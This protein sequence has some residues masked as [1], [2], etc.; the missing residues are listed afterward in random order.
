MKK[1]IGSFIV[2]LLSLCLVPVYAQP[3]GRGG[4]MTGMSVPEWSASMTKLFGDNPVFSAAMEHQSKGGGKDMGLKGKMS[5]DNGKSR[6]ELDMSSVTAQFPPGTLEQMKSMGLN[7]DGA[8]QITRPDKKMNYGVY[9]EM[10]AYTEDAMK[11][12]DAG[13]GGSD[14]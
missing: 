14:F 9:P 4:G 5:F 7:F 6:T 8:A 2:L 1:P 12:P 13:K 10:K 11:D 3:G